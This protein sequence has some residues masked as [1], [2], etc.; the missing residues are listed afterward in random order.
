MDLEPKVKG[1][2]FGGMFQREINHFVNCIQGKEEC[3]STID[4][5]LVVMRILD[6][7]YASAEKGK[8]VP[9]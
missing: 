9:V 7:V 1:E 8:E 2:D 4:D 3:I 6:A 5:G